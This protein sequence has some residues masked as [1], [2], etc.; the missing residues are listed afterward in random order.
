MDIVFSPWRL[1]YV[2]SPDKDASDCVF[3]RAFTEEPSLDNLVV[4]RDDKTAVMLNRYP[5]TN[6]HLLVIPRK[7]VDTLTGLDAQ[8]RA[9]LLEVITYSE[10]LLRG[11]YNPHGFNVGLN[12]GEAAGAGIITHLHFH[13]VPRW[14]GDTNFT[15]LF[16]NLRVIPEDLAGV[17][18]R[19]RVEYPEKIS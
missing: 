9:S 12:L 1:Q 5:Y 7:H 16:G 8:T 14:S 2:Q 6:G 17:F 3:C 18:E 4:Y 11:V 13:I 15:T 10:S 19:L